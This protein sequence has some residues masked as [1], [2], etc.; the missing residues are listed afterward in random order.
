MFLFRAHDR[1]Y[2]LPY[3]HQANYYSRVEQ[4]SGIWVE[5]EK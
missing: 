1:R 2:E 4:Q 5:T 3:L